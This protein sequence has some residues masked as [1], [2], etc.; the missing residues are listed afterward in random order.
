MRGIGISFP[1]VR[2][3]DGVDLSVGRGRVLALCGENGAGKSTLMKILAGVVPHGAY[4]G[5][6]RIDGAVVRFA[7][8]RDAEDRGVAIIHQ[9]LSLFPDL[10]VEEN[11]FVGRERA[12]RGVVDRERTRAEARALL[13]RLG[14][15][16]DPRTPVR[17]L[18]LAQA[19]LVE[20]ARALSRAADVLVLDE[21]TSALGEAEV[22]RLFG[23]LR[24]LRTEGLTMIYIS[25]RMDEIR[26][27]CDEAAVLRDG[28]A[29]LPPTPIARLT[30][31][32]IVRAMVGREVAAA[33]PRPAHAPGAPVL[34][35]RNRSV[36]HP[37][38][39]GAYVVRD[40]SFEV[41]AG[42]VLGIY[43]LMGA[44]RTEALTS[45]SGGYPPS[46]CEGD[47]RIEGRALRLRGP[48]DAIAAGIALVPEDRKGQG[49]VLG[50]SVGENMVLP[51][52]ADVAARGVVDPERARALVAAQ[53]ETLRVRTPS[54]AQ[55]VR[56]LSGGNQQKV[57]LGKWLARR[58][59]VLLL[60]EPTRGVDVGAKA[61]IHAI[62]GRLKEAGVA[63]VLA[64]S[65]LSELLEVSDRVMVMRAGRSRGFFD[66]AE[67][68]AERLGA[69]AT[70]NA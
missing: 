33:G 5:E 52:L 51:S 29:V 34:E 12:R 41:R 59:R 45:L 15:D 62:I 8:T 46:A 14:I 37:R 56:N 55:T 10:P 58:P 42:E 7:S 47:V 30:K 65:E 64:T 44:G 67:A 48:G 39:P 2:A 50:L 68:T 9:E 27:V 18:P 36:R 1:G 35:V 60:D 38:R 3:L 70:G 11:L 28:R 54:A 53:V 17:D 6:V 43:G 69:L 20:V 19:Q 22:E 66:R 57:V 23:I 13:A 49:L 40:L 61:E 4:E 21:P 26:A 25:H 32:E 63:V 24:G 31:D 16:V